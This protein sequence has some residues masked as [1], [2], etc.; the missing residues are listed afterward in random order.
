MK[1]RESAGERRSTTGSPC[2]LRSQP[3]SRSHSL[4]SDSRNTTPVSQTR[5]PSHMSPLHCLRTSRLADSC[6]WTGGTQSNLETP[7]TSKLDSARAATMT[8]LK[9]KKGTRFLGCSVPQSAEAM[10]SHDLHQPSQSE[11]EHSNPAA[12]TCCNPG[13]FRSHFQG[14]LTIDFAKTKLDAAQFFAGVSSST[15]SPV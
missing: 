5:F 2:S 8:G 12:P 3:R 10:M 4:L 6:D 1:S 9:R 7:R 14:I 15:E 13:T 11:L